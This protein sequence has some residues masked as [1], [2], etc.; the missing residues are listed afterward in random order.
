MRW[1]LELGRTPRELL[2]S[3]T[4]DEITEMMAFEQLAPFG[5][6]AHDHRAGT[7]AAVFA[8]ANR[9]VK[10][11]PAPFTAADFMPALHAA[12]QRATPAVKP[13]P[14]TKAQ[15]SA[16]LDRMLFGGGPR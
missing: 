15:R 14:M 5:A 4:S 13:K 7:I 1:A 12:R 2:A 9:D 3:T 10:K 8:N 6:L 16:A 11:Q